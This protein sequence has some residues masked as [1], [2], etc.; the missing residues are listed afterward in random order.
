M[1]RECV[2]HFTIAKHRLG[3]G[4]LKYNADR[5]RSALQSRRSL[6]IRLH[7]GPYGDYVLTVTRLEHVKRVDLAIDAF[8]KIAPPVR[9][10][11]AGDGSARR[12]LSEYIERRGAARP[13][14]A[15]RPR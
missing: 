6:P 12:E 9:L 2:G 10:L 3:I 11:I 8:E 15:A 4:M 1:L 7:D 5:V 14:D 13:G